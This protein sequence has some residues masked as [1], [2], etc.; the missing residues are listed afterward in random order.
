MAGTVNPDPTGSNSAAQRPTDG[1]VKA[2]TAA[3]V[4][5]PIPSTWTRP[6]AE[7]KGPWRMRWSTMASARA[8]PIPGS[9]QSSAMDARLRSI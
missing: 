3:A 9:A 2:A 8:G 1:T 4:S 7:R 6:S 5:G